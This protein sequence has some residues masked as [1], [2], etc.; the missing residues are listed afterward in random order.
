M[1]ILGGW[2]LLLCGC[3]SFSP[4]VRGLPG[5]MPDRVARHQLEVGGALGSVLTV[6]DTVHVSA[7]TIGG[8]HV[9]YGLLDH[10]VL[11]AGVNLALVSLHWATHWVGARVVHRRHIGGWVFSADGEL[12]VGAGGANLTTSRDFVAGGYSGGGVGFRWR[13]LGFF[14]RGRIDL[15]QAIGLPLLLW[16]TMVA[17]VEARAAGVFVFSFGGGVGAAW[18]GVG[19]PST[20]GLM[21]L[22]VSLLFDLQ[23]RV[24]SPPVARAL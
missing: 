14:T 7:P 2:S 23:P 12:G 1:R 10:L 8:P 15:S 9:A 19:P 18:S 21:E 6:S 11:E 24:V 13:W 4:P 16:P 20:F 5:G 3:V 22:S 17:G